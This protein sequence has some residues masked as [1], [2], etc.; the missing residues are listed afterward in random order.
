VT[1][2]RPLVHPEAMQGQ[3]Y[4]GSEAKNVGLVDR[5]GDENFALSCLRTAFR[6]SRAT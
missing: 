3:T 4:R 6:R 2:A 5:I 1:S